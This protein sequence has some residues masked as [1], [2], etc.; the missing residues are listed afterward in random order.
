MLQ[1]SMMVLTKRVGDSPESH[2]PSLE[3]RP[4]I[5]LHS[6]FYVYLIKIVL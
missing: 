2:I 4:T 3:V 6:L 5:I 1:A